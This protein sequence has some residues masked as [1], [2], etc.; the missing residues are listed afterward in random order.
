MIQA[1]NVVIFSILF[2]GK[3]GFTI[4]GFLRIISG[5]FK[6][7]VHNPF[8]EKDIIVM[9]IICFIIGVFRGR[10]KKDKKF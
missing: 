5:Y 3:F 1:P 6:Y 2:S 4:S 9:S 7:L 10:T 8:N